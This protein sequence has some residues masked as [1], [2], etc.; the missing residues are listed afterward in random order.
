M[1]IF[2]RFSYLSILQELLNKDDEEKKRKWKSF[3][4]VVILKFEA[5][6]CNGVCISIPVYS[7]KIR[8]ASK[9]NVDSSYK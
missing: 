8:N 7:H 5:Y 4:D 1:G 6:T 9:Y 3:R 2:F